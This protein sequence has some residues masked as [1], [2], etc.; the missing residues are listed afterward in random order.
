[1]ESP[2][3]KDLELNEVRWW[4]NWVQVRW[5]GPSGY[6]LSSGAIREPFFNRA[7]TVTCAGVGR[8]AAW[9]E[10]ELAPLGMDSTVTIFDSCA[11]AAR[12]LADSGYNPVD[13]MAVLISRGPI[14]ADNP[15]RASITSSPS[16]D[17]WSRTYLEAFYGEQKLAPLIVPTARHLLNLGAVTLMEA[18]VGGRAAGVLALFRSRGL[19]GAYCVGTVPEHRRRGV[20]ALLLSRARAI[21]DAEGRQLVLQSLASDGT[22][23]YYLE[24]GF[25]RLYCKMMLTKENSNAL[26]KKSA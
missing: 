17:S 12:A 25:V 2:S 7:G 20:A 16:A 15:L 10:R 19:A 14:R 5:I 9:A 3:R 13:S 4:A 24:R 23:H 11:H 18:R 6:L 1:M 8:T 21:A 26:H 22:E